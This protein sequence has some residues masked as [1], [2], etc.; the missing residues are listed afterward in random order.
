M[1]AKMLHNGLQ[2]SFASKNVVSLSRQNLTDSEISLLSE[3]LT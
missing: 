2:G 1:V 3:G